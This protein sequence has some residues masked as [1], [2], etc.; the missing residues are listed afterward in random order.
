[1]LAQIA[2]AGLLITSEPDNADVVVINTCGFIAPAKAESIEVIRHFAQRKRRGA[3]KKVIVAGCLGQRLGEKLFLEVEGIDAVIG[4]DKRDSIV[5][6]IRKTLS[7]AGSASYVDRTAKAHG[8]IIPDDRVRL[9][10]T[11][12]HWAYLR[13]SE[14]CDHRCSFCTI[15]SIRGRF[16]SKPQELVL[17][18]AKELASAGV[19]ELNLIGQD[20][21]HYGRDLKAGAGLPGLLRELEK[22]D[23]PA[24]IRL[25]YLYPAGIDERLI[26]TVAGSE[27]IV[28]Y[29]DI[30]IQHISNRVLKAM[31]RS[32]TREQIQRLIETLRR[33]MPD[34]TLRTTLIVGFPGESD[35]EFAELVDFV[36]WAQFDALGCFEYCREAGT[37]A[38]EMPDQIPEQ[39]KRQRL[40]ELMFAQQEIAFAR[41]KERGGSELKCLVDFA[42]INTGKG[43]FYG[44]APEIDSI[45]IIEKCSAKAGRLIKTKVV[46]TRD[47]DLLVEQV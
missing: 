5:R 13:I 38:A 7:S 40:E 46:G 47:Y 11:P 18:E 29:L 14:G 44:Q 43:R 25:M 30:P 22:I 45:C 36:R 26:E 31:R 33:S 3:V 23:G 12:G 20:T 24:W 28:H 37:S 34:V 17:A 19:V 41:N 21:S 27:R 10:I 16:R 4:L 6:I 9:L 8:D 42:D 1:M 32:D 15:P 35:R 2:Q 39:V